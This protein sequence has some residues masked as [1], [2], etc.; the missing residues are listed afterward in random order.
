MNNLNIYCLSV[1]PT[2]FELFKKMKYIP[3]GLGNNH[4][5]NRWLRDNTGKN[6]SFKNSYYAEFTFHYWFWKNLINTI[7]ENTWIGFCAYRRFWANNSTIN[8][9]DLDKIV[10]IKNFEKYA[11][12][13][14]KDEWNNYEVILGE[15]V[16][17][18]RIKLVK[19]LKNGGIKSILNN[20][21]IFLSGKSNI[22]FQFDI[23]H[24]SG[25]IEKAINLLDKNEKD[26]FYKFI[27]N[28]DCFNRGNMFICKSKKIIDKFYTSLF[29]WL[30]DCEKIFGFSEL[31]YNKRIY[32][33]LGERY[34]SYWF[35]KYTIY[36]E[37]PIFFFDT[38]NSSY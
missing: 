7:P 33:F 11:L 14:K 26:D 10:N 31:G 17:L 25:N 38:K 30:F 36:K 6:I 37:W 19:I 5:D 4:F 35:K 9:D 18:G 22:K 34:M 2:Q 1:Y 28:E 15:V 20:Y 27:V 3:V 16:R 12:H 21:K 29:K 32:G 8:S 23:F 13:E 24:G